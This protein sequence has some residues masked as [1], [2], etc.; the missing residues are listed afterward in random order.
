MFAKDFIYSSFIAIKTSTTIREARELM[1]E[2]KVSHLPIVNNDILL[3]ILNEEDLLGIKDES[4]PI[5]N[6][7][8]STPIVSVQSDS[9]IFDILQFLGQY[10]LSICPVTSSNMQYLGSIVGIDLLQKLSPFMNIDN[11]GGTIILEIKPIDYTMTQIASIVESND[12]HILA[13][14]IHADPDK[15]LLY[16]F[17]KLDKMDLAP[18]V[19]TFNRYD[20][21]IYASYQEEEFYEEL[22]HNY[23]FLMR[24]LNI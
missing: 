7:D 3:G 8:L 4:I 16:V 23:D 24:F 13:T 2:W 5:G 19:Q 21:I 1:N 14:F 20:Y 17:L 18:I 10:K 9:H 12:A 11:P 15:N 6:V 22:Q